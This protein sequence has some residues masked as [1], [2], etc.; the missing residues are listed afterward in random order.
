MQCDKATRTQWGGV[1]GMKEN[2]KTLARR[3]VEKD[4][5]RNGVPEDRIW[6]LLLRLIF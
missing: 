4:N 1:T 2:V 3:N 5:K 6:W